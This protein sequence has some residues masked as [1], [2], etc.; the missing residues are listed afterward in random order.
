M[1][2]R[3]ERVMRREMEDETSEVYLKDDFD[4]HVIYCKTELNIS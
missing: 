1:S 2:W 3:K 4:F